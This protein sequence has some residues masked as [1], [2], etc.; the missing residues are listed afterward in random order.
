MIDLNP[1]AIESDPREASTLSFEAMLI[2]EG[3]SN[4]S[5]FHKIVKKFS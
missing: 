5:L 1:L 3:N 2:F 4:P